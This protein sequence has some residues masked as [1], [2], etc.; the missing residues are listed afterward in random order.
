[1][2]RESGLTKCIP[3]GHKM[4]VDALSS[5]SI[6]SPSMGFSVAFGWYEL[7]RMIGDDCY[8][9]RWSLILAT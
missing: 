1:M 8:C 5:V 3:F 6:F 7:I 4:E 9:R 2:A